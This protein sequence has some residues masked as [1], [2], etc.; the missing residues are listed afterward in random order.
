VRVKSFVRNLLDEYDYSLTVSDT[1]TASITN[2]VISE[3]IDIDKVITINNLK[4]PARAR[5]NWRSSREVLNMVFDPDGDYYTDKIKPE[6]I[7]TIALSVGAKSMQFGLTNTVLQPN[8]NGNKNAVSVKGG[9]LTHYTIDETEARLWNLADNTTTFSSDTSAYYIYAKCERTGTAGSIIF[10]TTQIKTEQDA[11]YYHFWIGVVNSVDTKLNARSIAL[12][13]GFSM[14][15]GRFIS[16]GRIQSADG[17]TYFDLDNNEIVGNIKFLSGLVSGRVG[18]GN[19][20]GVNAG[21]S[22]E[23]NSAGDVRIWAGASEGN[24]GSAPFKVMHDGSVVMTNATVTGTVYA[25]N[26]KFTGEVEAIR[27]KIGNFIISGGGLTNNNADGNGFATVRIRANLHEDTV[28]AI[29]T[30]TLSVFDTKRSPA[31]FR[32]GEREAYRDNCAVILSAYNGRN[33][34]AIYIESG[35]I[36]GFAVKLRDVSSSDT[37]TRED[38]YIVCSN[39]TYE[40]KLYLSDRGNQIGK[41]YYIKRMYGDGDGS[42]VEVLC[43]RR[44][45]TYESVDS[46]NLPH[47]DV[48]MFVWDGS[49]WHF[50]IMIR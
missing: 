26:G 33:N 50:S 2:R 41:I 18:I 10:S 24:R 42:G 46:V 27:G 4:D 38:C 40:I 44:I 32:S 13:Y 34:Y 45:Y 6:S 20:N 23:G 3:L 39:K 7:D 43:A 21:M 8:Y 29:G 5:A 49:Y 47:G 30:D 12:S 1:V 31:L 14:I 9:V 35:N 48:A 28:A 36:A 15:N 37:L 25:T 11:G 19:A 22:G 17:D 16:T